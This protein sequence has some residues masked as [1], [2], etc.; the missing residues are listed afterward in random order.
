[1]NTGVQGWVKTGSKGFKNGSKG[2]QKVVT[3][4]QWRVT[5]GLPEGHQ[6]GQPGVRQGSPGGQWRVTRGSLVYFHA[7]V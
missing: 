6:G 1:M 4:N 7:A 2:V 3:K 5:R